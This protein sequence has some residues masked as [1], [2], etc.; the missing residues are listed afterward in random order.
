MSEETTK[1]L[2]IEQIEQIDAAYRSLPV[3]IE[4][5][6]QV[7]IN[8]SKLKSAIEIATAAR[9]TL[10]E[11]HVGKGTTSI[12]TTHPKFNDVINGLNTIKEKQMTITGLTKIGKKD[13]RSEDLKDK[14]S[15]IA[16]LIGHDLFELV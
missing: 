12:P 14:Q 11:E 5:I 16:T 7:A 4:K 9:N 10:L 8:M 2:T 3:T 13:L 15:D 6:I 1:T